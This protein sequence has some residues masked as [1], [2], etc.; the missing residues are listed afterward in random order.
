MT[1]PANAAID[2]EI[3]REIGQVWKQVESRVLQMAGGDESMLEKDLTIESVISSLNQTQASNKKE[4]EKYGQVRNVFQRTLQCIQTVGGIVTTGVST[5]FAPAS[6]C[7]NA[8]SFVIQAWQGY[9]GIFDSL[10]SLLEKCIEFMDRLSIYAQ[11]GMDSKLTMVACLH[12]QIFV[13]ICDRCLKLR[14]KRHK[15]AAFMK[16]LF[17]NDDGV[18]GLLASMSGLVDKERG[19]VAAQTWKSSIEAAENSRDGL[20]LTRKMHASLMEDKSMLR[21][22]KDIK[23]WKQSIFTTLNCAQDILEDAS[24]KP[25]DE[26][27]NRYKSSILQDTGEWLFQDAKFTSWLNGNDSKDRIL[28]LQG[29]AGTGKTLL[30]ANFILNIRKGKLKAPEYLGSRVVV[31]HNFMDMETKPTAVDDIN[32]KAV[33]MSSNLICQ[34]ALADES[35]MKSI[36][37]ICDRLKYLESPKEMWSELLFDNE[38]LLSMDITLFIVFDR[39]IGSIRHFCQILQGLMNSPISDRIRIMITGSKDFFRELETVGGIKVAKIPLVQSN[40]SDIE[41]YIKDRMD[42][43][44]ILKEK[45]PSV[46]DIRARILRELPKSTEGDYHKINRVLDNISKT[47][48]PDEVDFQLESARRPRP[49]QIEAD[50]QKLNQSLS[51]REI[52]EINEMILWL[53]NGML[54]KVDLAMIEAAIELGMGDYVSPSLMS[55]RSKIKSKYT[56]FQVGW[57]DTV[58]YKYPDIGAMIPNKAST[59]GSQIPNDD[60]EVSATEINILKHYLSTVCPKYLYDKVGFEDFLESKLVSKGSQIHQDLENANILLALRC[61]KCL[62]EERSEK[63][64][65]LYEHSQAFLI[66]Y[67]NTTDLSLADRELKSEAGVMLVRL[68]TEQYAI[69][70]LLGFED[71]KPVINTYFRYGDEL[72]PYSWASWVFGQA[73]VVCISRWFSDSAVIEDVKDNPIIT[74]FNDPDADHR[75]VLLKLGMLR[76]ANDLFQRDTAENETR[77]A[78]F[79]LYF[80]ITKKKLPHL[81]GAYS[82]T[83]EMFQL[84]E[85][86]SQ[87]AL[88]LAEKDA[89][90]EARAVDVIQSVTQHLPPQTRA[91]CV[92]RA[93]RAVD[94]D[95][96]CWQGL[97]ALSRAGGRNEENINILKGVVD[98]LIADEG[99]TS[100]PRNKIILT[101]ILLDLTL[102]FDHGRDERCEEINLRIF[103]IDR[104]PDVLGKICPILEIYSELEKWDA[105]ITFYERLLEEPDKDQNTTGAFLAQNIGEYPLVDVTFQ[106]IKAR[107]RYD[108]IETLFN[109]AYATEPP[110]QE[111]DKLRLEHGRMLTRLEGYEEA[112]LS[113]WEDC[114]QIPQDEI[115]RFRNGLINVWIKLAYRKGASSV[116]AESYHTKLQAYYS[117]FESDIV[118]D[119]QSCASMAQ[120]FF[121]TGDEQKAKELLKGHVSGALE[122]LEDDDLDNDTVSLYTLSVAS[123]AMSDLQNALVAWELQYIAFR[124]QRHENKRRQLIWRQKQVAEMKDSEDLGKRAGESTEEGQVAGL[125]ETDLLDHDEINGNEDGAHA[126][127][128]VAKLMEEENE[129]TE[130]VWWDMGKQLA[131]EEIDPMSLMSSGLTYC[132]NCRFVSWNNAGMWLCLTHAGQRVFHDDCYKKLMDGNAPASECSKDDEFYQFPMRDK[133]QAKSLPKGCVLVQGEVV[134]YERWKAEI[135]DKY[136]EF[137]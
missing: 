79:F 71:F 7:Y 8:L 12:L 44:D 60:T 30:A 90:W 96:N 82:A 118:G 108:L 125:G 4:A 19:L 33:L 65:L 61:M 22:E 73:G 18:Q 34:L 114:R 103:E 128:L 131:D 95:P 121:R 17:L 28:G 2:S 137:E 77:M 109:K 106:A 38:D 92:R 9:E 46:V 21:K 104:S 52:A 99:W 53:N 124:A 123:C 48:D 70:S 31:A 117:D 88:E 32:S 133:E 55:M 107:N 24:T 1:L 54:V 113:M 67:L 94:F 47:D 40:E 35:L 84:V 111:L 83:Y 76:A 58:E 42:H 29:E 136:V 87:A 11:G 66:D 10:T 100:Q 89:L 25:W 14:Q 43:M 102:S 91:E 69:G 80:L 120:Y 127:K 74:A 62:V 93:K 20:S 97:Y 105:I 6:T 115:N 15:L 50:I 64:Q 110:S 63:T 112:G 37:S 119:L 57:N 81:D 3:S 26:I 122:M 78:F 45:T 68:F 126:S 130:E 101:R 59:R 72:F 132:H 75:M 49:E 39:I 56:L 23:V 86:W 51:K 13:E 98:R 16:Q 129:N 134:E 5:V 85:N 41:I 27:W 116:D 36:A 135:R